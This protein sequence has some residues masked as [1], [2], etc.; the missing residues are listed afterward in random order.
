M[1][2]REG[3]LFCKTIGNNDFSY[4]NSGKEEPLL[5]YVILPGCDLTSFCKEVW[6]E[7]GRAKKKSYPTMTLVICGKN[8][9]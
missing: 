6:K 3:R 5:V 7:T 1:I 8:S 2:T 4:C 9:S